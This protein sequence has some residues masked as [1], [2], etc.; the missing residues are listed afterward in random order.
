MQRSQNKVIRNLEEGAP[1]SMT[2]RDISCD[3]DLEA[4]LG[5]EEDS[6]SEDND[7]YFL[8]CKIHLVGFDASEM[9]GL[10][11]MVRRGSGS[12]YMCL[13]DQLTH[14]VVGNASIF[15]HANHLSYT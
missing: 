2:H 13:N 11:N 12:R 14:V 9:H 10:V 7:L 4:T 6:Q 1:I 3:A 8:N 15:F 5:I